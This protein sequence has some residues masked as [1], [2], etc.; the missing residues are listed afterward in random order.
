[1][2]HLR[3][4]MIGCLCLGSCEEDICG[5]VTASKVPR[6]HQVFAIRCTCNDL[7]LKNKGKRC[8]VTKVLAMSSRDLKKSYTDWW[9]RMME[10]RKAGT[11]N[12]PKTMVHRTWAWTSTGKSSIRAFQQAP[13][14]IPTNLNNA[15]SLTVGTCIFDS[16]G[17][18]A[19]HC[20]A[21]K[22]VLLTNLALPCYIRA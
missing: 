11:L 18:K 20:N 6:R 21:R 2:W 9:R 14:M 5:L 1:M 13:E 19:D 12:E 8:Q 16:L 3:F 17:W 15:S 4:L 22:K 10:I 7:L